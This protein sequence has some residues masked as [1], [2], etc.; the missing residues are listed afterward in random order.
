MIPL[1]SYRRRDIVEYH[2]IGTYSRCNAMTDYVIPTSLFR[3][4]KLLSQDTTR[5]MRTHKIS[6]IISS[7]TA[8]YETPPRHPP[9]H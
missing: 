1:L 7:S 2:T 9:L 5:K 4:D 3:H 6:C 8:V